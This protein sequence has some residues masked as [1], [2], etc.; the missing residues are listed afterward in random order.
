[1]RNDVPATLQTHLETRT[2][3]LCWCWR[4]ARR[5]GVIMGF[6]NH[7]RD[8]SFSEP[9]GQDPVTFEAST[10]FLGTE[11]ESQ[12]G[13]NVDN[14][15]V[16]G[17]LD[18]ANIT[19]ADI[20]A[21]R[22]DNADVEIHLVNWSDVSERVIMQRGNLG[23][24]K[25]GQVMFEA[26]LRGISHQL[27]ESRGRLYN[28]RCDALLGDSRCAKVITGG[29][30]TGTGTVTTTNGTSSMIASGLASYTTGWFSGGK[31]TFTS[32][33][34][35]T[36]AREV[37]FHSLSNAI[38]EIYM[39]EPFPFTIAAADTFDIV[40]GCDKLFATCKSKFTNEP[41]FRGFP[42]VPGNS[43]LMYYAV[44]GDPNLDGGGNFLGKD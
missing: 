23:N 17:A 7:D 41:N 40:A 2:T 31:L 19:E 20:E 29:T 16:F 33:L 1:M 25:R 11:I 36:I 43:T 18:S 44:A 32:G 13:M 21:G 9:I 26:E 5:D 35:D 28:Y 12:L 14:M 10:G 15:D 37:K 6:T 38:V 39:W 8:L 4:I 42:H 27:Q 24:V 30:Y 34:N 22:Y 3:T